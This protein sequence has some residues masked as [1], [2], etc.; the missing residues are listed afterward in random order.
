MSLWHPAIVGCVA[1][2]ILL[3][4]SILLGLFGSES[5][6]WIG[7][8][9]GILLTVGFVACLI[10][11]IPSRTRRWAGGLLIGF[12]VGLGVALV[13]FAGVCVVAFATYDSGY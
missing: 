3:S 5:L 8:A 1:S 6:Y 11:L 4:A 10:L 12:F 9:S 7:S 13:I 2:V